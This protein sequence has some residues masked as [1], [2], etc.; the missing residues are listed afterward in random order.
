MSRSI[1][2]P[3]SAPT[4]SPTIR[5]RPETSADVARADALAAPPLL[6]PRGEPVTIVHL[7]AEYSPYARTGG[8]AEAVNGLASFQHAAGHQTAVLMPLYRT[9][10]DEAP[11]L[12]PVGHP[13]RVPLG[14]APEEA[15]LF[16]VAA[17]P[18]DRRSISSSTSTTSTGPTFTARRAQTT[19]T[20][21]AASPSSRWRRASR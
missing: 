1:T 21:R 14:G 12:Q 13:F 16:R 15:R 17:D 3:R 9:V 6:N 18:R 8:L 7:T 4:A 2:P 11:D 10:R 5:P 19:R 20:T